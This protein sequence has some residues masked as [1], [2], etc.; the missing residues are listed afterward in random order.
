MIDIVTESLGLFEIDEKQ[1]VLKA[2]SKSG[3]CWHQTARYRVSGDRLFPIYKNTEE[4]GG[5][6]PEGKVRITT[7]GEVEERAPVRQKQRLF[8]PVMCRWHLPDNGG[9]STQRIV[10]PAR[11]KA[12]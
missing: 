8:Y 9:S 1:K 2:S 11:W 7:E 5:D 4:V 6:V 10:N 3:C 12:I